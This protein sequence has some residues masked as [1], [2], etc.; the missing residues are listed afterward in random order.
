VIFLAGPAAAE[1]VAG[2]A[3]DGQKGYLH[4]VVK[5]DTLWWITHHYLGTSWVWP[6][7]WKENEEIRNPHLIYPG[8]LVWITENGMR[9][10]SPE[11]AEALLTGSTPGSPLKEG[12]PGAVADFPPDEA[13]PFSGLDSHEALEGRSMF[14]PG[15]HRLSFVTDEEI[16]ASAAVLGNHAEYY[17]MSQTQQMI[18]SAGEGHTDIGENFTVFRVRRRVMHPVTRKM[19]GYMVEILGRAEIDEVHPETSFARVVTAYS[20]IEPGD[21]LLPYEEL[22]EEIRSRPSAEPVSGMIVAQQPHRIWSAGG[23]VVVLDR[24]R[25]DGLGAGR[26]LI[27][28][29]PGRSVF[30]PITESPVMEPDDLVA[31]VFVLRAGGSNSI[32]VVTD[33]KREIHEGDHF[34]SP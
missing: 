28:Y 12:I 22:P 31:R 21:R 30:D 18:V 9:K 23:D 15:I 33:A 26:E 25:D 11:E 7:I 17:W 34:R 13:D 3:P 8:D 20:E 6:S 32:A 19:L 14:F 24:G 29:R 10:V 2:V 5:G 27:V 1:R 4:R 16:D